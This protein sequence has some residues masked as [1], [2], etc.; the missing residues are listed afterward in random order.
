MPPIELLANELLERSA[1]KVARPVLRGGWQ[2][3]LPSLPD[4][5]YYFIRV[6]NRPGT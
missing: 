3:D 6:K 4:F 1:V 2:S 5:L